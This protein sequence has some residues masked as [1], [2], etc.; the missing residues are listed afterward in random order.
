MVNFF[1][2]GLTPYGVAAL[3][4]FVPW[5]RAGWDLWAQTFLHLASLGL[6][7][8]YL[9]RA[10]LSET[11]TAPP[12]APSLWIG[13]AF[14]GTAASALFSVTP[15]PSALVL[16]QALSVLMI[17]YLVL[18]TPQSHPLYAKTLV[19]STL[20][21]AVLGAILLFRKDS[22]FSAVFLNPNVFG[23]T[24][25]MVLPLTFYCAKTLPEAQK[26]PFLW[27]AGIALAAA[28]FLTGSTA[29]ILGS[30]IAGGATLLWGKNRKLKM[31]AGILLGF[32]AA[33]FLFKLREPW[34]WN[35]WIWWKA[36][37][38]MVRENPILGVGP[39]GFEFHYPRFRSE[40]LSSLYAHCWPLQLA[41][42]N[43]LPAFC[44][45]ITGLALIL[46]RIKDRMILWALAGV[47][48]QST[49]DYGLLLPANALIFWVLIAMG[50]AP[51]AKRRALPKGSG[52]YVAVLG[53]L[54]V[55]LLA[56]ASLRAWS[57]SRRVEFGK[58]YASQEQWAPAE[59]ELLRAAE[60]NPLA[61][62]PHAVLSELYQRRY[63]EEGPTSFL[64]Q[65]WVERGLALKRNPLSRSSW[66][67]WEE[68]QTRLGLQP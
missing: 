42:E 59:T 4:I 55:A 28:L 27:S 32:A 41:A 37:L 16:G 62:E 23:C 52:A 65:A 7:L 43:G 13:A 11:I 39:G 6:F 56:Q 47:L 60:E 24:L 10:S 45:L 34:L 25:V 67:Q 29:G 18:A 46:R 63:R 48:L 61:E 12:K 22:L 36:A 38:A 30:A 40:G 1:P 9:W 49:V 33:I 51:A 66:K 68:I 54:V 35:R 21:Q 14:L 44:A 17:A 19:L 15:G 57:S 31:A 53:T 2:P 5:A 50:A 26:R 64:Y 20:A 8:E 58:Y 3:L